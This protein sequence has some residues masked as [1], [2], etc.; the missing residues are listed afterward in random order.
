MLRK[1]GATLI[2]SAIQINKVLTSLDL[3]NM[4]WHIGHSE[5]RN[6]GAIWIAKALKDNITL[7]SFNL[8]TKWGSL[9]WDRSGRSKGDS[10]RVEE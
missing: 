2:A 3:S 6:K 4:K 5:I 9:W 1:K 7:I 8:H 10:E